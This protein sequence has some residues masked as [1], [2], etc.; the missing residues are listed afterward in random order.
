MIKSLIPISNPPVLF[1]F[2]IACLTN[3]R[4]GTI[5]EAHYKYLIYSL[6]NI[7]ISTYCYNNI[8]IPTFNIEYEFNN[9]NKKKLSNFLY[10]WSL[11]VFFSLLFFIGFYFYEN[12]CNCILLYGLF[13]L[14]DLL[15][16]YAFPCPLSLHPHPQCNSS[17]IKLHLDDG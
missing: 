8:N 14:I 7:I 1:G 2:R 13:L 9:N 4:R 3:S 12:W 16:Y 17:L 10:Y 6:H 15:M 5:I 11:D